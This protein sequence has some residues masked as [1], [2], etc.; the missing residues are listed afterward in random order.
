M[1]EHNGEDKYSLKSLKE[2]CFGDQATADLLEDPDVCADAKRFFAGR[3]VEHSHL[4]ERT[5]R[6][7]LV[8]KNSE[9]YRVER[10]EEDPTPWCH[11]CGA[12]TAATCDCG[13]I[14]ENE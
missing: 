1:S 10:E 11:G 4:H 3:I 5:K 13:P 7:I 9:F 14:A 12:M 2:E 6:P 8:D